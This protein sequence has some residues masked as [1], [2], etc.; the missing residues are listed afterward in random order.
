MKTLNTLT[1]CAAM[2]FLS[3]SAR[4]ASYGDAVG[5]FTGGIGALDITSVNVNNDATTLTFTVN[6]A[7]DPTAASWYNYHVGISE[8]LF[9]GAGGNMNSTGGWGKDIQMS[10]G[11]MDFWVGSWGTGSS[12]YAWTGSA[13]NWISGPATSEDSSSLTLTVALSDL[14]LTAG[15]SFKFDVWTSDTGSDIVLDALSDTTARSWNS[16]PFDTGSKWLS[17]EVAVVPEPGALSLLGLGAV[18]GIL[19]RRNCRG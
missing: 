6:F 16:T 17:Y 9:G 11:G 12:L 14:N 15:N 8:N 19:R 7:G 4:A 10:Q 3:T 13:W 5:D 18:A 2:A 1:L